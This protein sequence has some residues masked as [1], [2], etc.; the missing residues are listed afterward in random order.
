MPNGNKDAA[1][2]CDVIQVITPNRIE[3]RLSFGDSRPSGH[4]PLAGVD[5]P[6]VI[7]TLARAQ[8]IAKSMSLRR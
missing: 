4:A 8:I 3:S 2:S 1:Q 7:V 5:D 6:R